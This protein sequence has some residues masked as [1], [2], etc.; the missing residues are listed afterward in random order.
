MR[1]LFPL[2]FLFSLGLT[3]KRNN[4]TLL[5]K[6]STLINALQCGFLLSFIISLISNDTLCIF[7][8]HFQLLVKNLLSSS[9]FVRQL[10]T[11]YKPHHTLSFPWLFQ[12]MVET[13]MRFPSAFYWL[14]NGSD[15][16]FLHTTLPQISPPLLWEPLLFANKTTN[17][18]TT[19]LWFC[20]LWRMSTTLSRDGVWRK[21]LKSLLLLIWTVCL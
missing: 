6:L 15:T 9:T 8:L 17:T 2:L 19:S 13:S 18:T 1:W 14:K 5:F 21:T 3:G 20:L 16:T 10:K 7:G 11:F 12:W 4:L